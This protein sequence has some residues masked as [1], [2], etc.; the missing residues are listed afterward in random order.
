MTGRKIHAKSVFSAVLLAFLPLTAP[1]SA[2]AEEQSGTPSEPVGKALVE[3]KCTICHSIDRVHEAEKTHSEW[4][5]TIAK[6]MR[7][8]DQMDFL[9]QQ[10]R[11]D[12]IDYLAGRKHSQA[13][14]AK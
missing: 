11:D 6:M 4:E 12:I 8:S 9:N 13:D 7:Y 3:K 14:S 5:Q 2:L 1:F 10:E